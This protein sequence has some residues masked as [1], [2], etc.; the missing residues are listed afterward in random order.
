[1]RQLSLFDEPQLSRNRDPKTSHLAA[2]ETKKKLNKLQERVLSVFERGI[3]LTA[4]EAA[5]KCQEKYC[6]DMNFHANP[7][8]CRKRLHELERN[9]HLEIVGQRYCVITHRLATAYR[10]IES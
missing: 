3:E 10:R 5:K 4:Q 8:T 6:T 7:E 9:E 1:M 2:E